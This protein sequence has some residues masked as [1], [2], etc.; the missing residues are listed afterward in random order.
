MSHFSTIKLLKTSKM[1]G[2]TIS[3][4]LSPHFLKKRPLAVVA[5]SLKILCGLCGARF[6][7]SELNTGF[8]MEKTGLYLQ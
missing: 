6:V 5:L 7:C 3:L 1:G 4:R 8:G 2:L